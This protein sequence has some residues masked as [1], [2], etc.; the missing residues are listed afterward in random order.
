MNI[1]ILQHNEF[2]LFAVYVLE[3]FLSEQENLLVT[4]E[5]QKCIQE[6]DSLTYK[7]NV[8]AEMSSWQSALKRE[9]LNFFFKKVA[10][11]AMII[12]KMRDPNPNRSQEL[13]FLDA[14]AMKHNKNDYTRRHIH[15]STMF[16]GSYNCLVPSSEQYMF[17]PDFEDNVQM[18]SNQLIF[19]HGLTKHS[20]NKNAVEHPRYSLAFNMEIDP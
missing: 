3:D 5:V 19:F 20:V 13:N 18:K 12:Y 15:G 14:W 16:S 4:Q 10:D 9:N 1:K 6:D 8:Q 11:M 17:F 2:S 7:T